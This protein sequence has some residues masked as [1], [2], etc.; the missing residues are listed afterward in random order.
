MAN[1]QQAVTVDSATLVPT[2]RTTYTYNAANLTTSLL[3]ESWV[4]GAWRN[5]TQFL[6]AYDSQGRT[7]EYIGQGWVTN[8]WVT[9]FGYQIRYVYDAQNRVTEQTQSDWS[10]TTRTFQPTSRYQ[11]SYAGTT[12]NYSSYVYQRWTNNAWVNS[13]QQNAFVYDAQ[14]RATYYETQTWTNATTWQLASRTTSS[15]PAGGGS[16]RLTEQLVGGIWQNSTRFTEFPTPNGIGT[17]FSNETWTGSAWQLDSG[18]RFTDVF[19]ATNDLIR[20]FR[21]NVNTTTRAWVNAN[22]FYY[23]NFQSFVLATNA[24]ALQAQTQLFPNPT[25]GTATLQL[26]GLRPQRPV[27]IAVFNTLGQL[28]QAQAVPAQAGTVS[29][30]LDVR[31]LPAGVYSVRLHAA[32]GTVVKRLIKQ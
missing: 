19:N 10:T 20:R 9:N 16:V 8:A 32:E 28:V 30:V 15:F 17:G 25:T 2:I 3:D 26:G 18:N 5:T 24:P 23:S 11:Y 22:K 12:S 6:Y 31:K 13:T 29:Q 4:A 21:Q 7:T 27:Q 1:V 14:G